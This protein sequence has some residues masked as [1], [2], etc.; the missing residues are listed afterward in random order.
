LQG[1]ALGTLQKTG[2]DH[3][4]A[5][6]SIAA[7]SAVATQPGD[8]VSAGPPPPQAR[9]H[10]SAGRGWDVRWFKQQRGVT[11]YNCADSLDRTNVGS[12]FGAVQVFVEQ[13]RELDIAI[14]ATSAGAA[15]VAR[16]AMLRRQAAATAA[17]A[18]AALGGGA[19]AD[20]TAVAAAAAA[21]GRQHL[22]RRFKILR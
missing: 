1:Y 9:G 10:S 12:F 20:I 14:A 6:S 7:A 2:P 22:V 18:A 3:T 11:R 16:Q 4:D 8:L 17:A 15:S 13:C 19:A 21:A 5:S